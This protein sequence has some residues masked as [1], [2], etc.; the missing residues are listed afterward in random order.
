MHF[1]NDEPEWPYFCDVAN[2]AH[3]IGKFLKKWGRVNVRQTKEKFGTARV[4]CNFGWY[5]L[6]DIFYPGY[7]RNQFPAWLWRLDCNYA[8]H[9]MRIINPLITAYHVW[10]YKLAYKKAIKKWPHIKK[11]II[12]G[13]DYYLVKE[14]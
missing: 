12:Y 10:L 1:Y 11:E 8:P 2:A 9:I 14:I 13:A 3:F 4:Y 6:H 7:V 5:Q